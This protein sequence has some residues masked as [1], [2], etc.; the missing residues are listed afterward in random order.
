MNKRVAILGGGIAGMSAAHELVER[1]FQ[2]A[3]Y[4]M[5]RIAGGKARSI[6]VPNTG[7]DGRKDLPGEHGFRFFPGF[8][9]HLPDTMKRIPYGK[10]TVFDNLVI[11]ESTLIA[12]SGGEGDL[13]FPAQPPATPTDLFRRFKTALDTDLGFQPGEITYYIGRLLTLLTTCTERRFAQYEYIDWWSFVGADE[14]SKAY[15]KY[16]AEGIT[17]SCVACRA[18]EM[19]AR[20]GGYLLLQ[21][22]FDL[23]RPGVQANRVLNGPTSEVW[24]EP[25]RAYLQRRGVDY[26]PQAKVTKINYAGGRISGV[27][28][29][30]NG[31]NHSVLADYYIAALPVEV[32]EPRVVPDAINEAEPLI[33]EEMKAADPTLAH[34]D[35]LKTEWMNGIQFYLKPDVPVV[36]G[37]TLF[38]DSPWALTTV[39][40][41]QFWP[42]VKLAEYGDGSVE[43]ILSV[44]ISN[45]NSEGILYQKPARRCTPEEIKEEVWQQIKTH[46]NDDDVHELNHNATIVHWFLDEA[47][48]YPNPNAME[49]AEPLLI[50]TKGTWDFRPEAVTGI[51]NFFLAADYVRTHTDLATMEAAN[52]AA[53]RAVNGILEA[54]GSKAKRCKIWPLSEPL[55]FAPLRWYDRRRF[56]KDLPHDQRVINL[57]LLIGVPIW[58]VVHF[59]WKVFYFV[60]DRVLSP[61][62]RFVRRWFGG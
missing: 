56:K 32:M 2:V 3:V 36:R 51:K 40:Q 16:C 21:L 19:S 11:T 49:N 6:P 55:V 41:K 37:H 54:S 59:Q 39:C 22:L 17:R 45:W 25:W 33:T 30:E 48:H 62:Y 26:H 34:L 57:A 31:S 13:A 10:K 47:I 58:R 52:E 18:D 46:L 35:K 23:V 24:L 9:K 42:D 5:R 27:T 53:R 15:Q 60:T 12:R 7:V 1:G 4:E 28:I 38:I 8:Y 43:G 14:R 44:D 29:E 61:M 20:T 50:N